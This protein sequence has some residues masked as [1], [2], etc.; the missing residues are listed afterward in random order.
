MV[1]FMYI[2]QPMALELVILRLGRMFT[3]STLKQRIFTGHSKLPCKFYQIKK[4]NN[5]LLISLR[6]HQNHN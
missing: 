1:P 5:I 6:A 2:L 3:T 4:V